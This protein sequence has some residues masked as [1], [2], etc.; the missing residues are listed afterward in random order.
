MLRLVVIEVKHRQRRPPSLDFSCLMLRPLIPISLFSFGFALSAVAEDSILPVFKTSCIQCH[1]EKGKVKGKVNL[2]EIDSVSAL[3]RD[4]ELLQKIFEAIDLQEMPP[5]D[6]TPLKPDA[7]T[8]LLADLEVLRHASIKTKAY[9]QTPIRR[10]NRFQYNN[11]VTDLFDLDCVVFTL[12]ERMMRDHKDYFQPE[13]GKMADVVTVGSRPLGKSQLIEPRLTAR[14]LL[15]IP[16]ASL[17]PLGRGRRG[18][19]GR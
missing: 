5:E 17:A 13:T 10:M 6:E 2:L 18:F 15:F 11:A 12:P 14:N 1:G 8:K 3:T 9:A 7:R 16:S 4:P 19:R